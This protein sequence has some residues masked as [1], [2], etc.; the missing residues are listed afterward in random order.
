MKNDIKA[1]SMVIVGSTQA[2]GRVVAFKRTLRTMRET[3]TLCFIKLIDPLTG[4]FIKCKHP[5]AATGYEGLCYRCH[6][7]AWIDEVYELT[8]ETIDRMVKAGGLSKRLIVNKD[9]KARYVAHLA[10]L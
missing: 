7:S 9:Q 10:E 3:S 6:T 1:D 8:E 2:V 4:A 5:V